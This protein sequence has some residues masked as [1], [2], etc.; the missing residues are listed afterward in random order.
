M[1]FSCIIVI[2][3]I[4]IIII[5]I[6]IIVIIIIIII[7]IQLLFAQLISAY[8][9]VVFIRSQRSILVLLFGQFS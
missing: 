9:T 3:I 2:M 4:M 1:C 5:I 8:K 6:I 7:I